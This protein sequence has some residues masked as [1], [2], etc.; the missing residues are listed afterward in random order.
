MKLNTPNSING[1]SHEKFLL[2]IICT[3]RLFVYNKK[4]SKKHK[5]PPITG[6][7]GTT[8]A[9]GNNCFNLTR[10][11]LNTHEITRHEGG[12]LGWL[13]VML[14]FHLW[15]PVHKL[16]RSKFAHMVCVMTYKNGTSV[17]PRTRMSRRKLCSPGTIA[18][19]WVGC[20][21]NNLFRI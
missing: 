14:I 1:R 11:Q 21:V 5:L 8:A 16:L 12:H 10:L 15:T 6:Y 3:S 7:I 19:L 17:L 20:W 13:E 4:C 9:G 2:G 18:W